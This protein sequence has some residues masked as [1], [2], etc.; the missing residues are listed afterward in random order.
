MDCFDGIE[1]KRTYASEVFW[2][3]Y[4]AQDS[5]GNKIKLY[6]IT[7]APDGMEPICE[8]RLVP[9]S[10]TTIEQIMAPVIVGWKEV[11]K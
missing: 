6:G 7:E 4:E 3:E 8:D 9:K 5:D 11:T 10:T 2:W 1:F